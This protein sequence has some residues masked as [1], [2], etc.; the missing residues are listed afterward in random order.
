MPNHALHGIR[1]KRD[2]Q[3]DVILLKQTDQRHLSDLIQ[4]L[5][6]IGAVAGDFTGG[7]LD[8]RLV[9]LNQYSC[10]IVVFRLLVFPN[11]RDGF[12]HGLWGS[13]SFIHTLSSLR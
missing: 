6:Q 11:E 4:V 13:H 8:H 1:F 12:V 7:H 5:V 3:A 9:F 10:N 2:T